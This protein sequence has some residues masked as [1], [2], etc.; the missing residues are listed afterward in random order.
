MEKS[1]VPTVPDTITLLF[2]QNEDR[3]IDVTINAWHLGELESFSECLSGPSS[4]AECLV[5]LLPLVEALARG[6]RLRDGQL[7]W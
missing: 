7:D 1:M 2:H 4:I 3:C 5:Q 6:E